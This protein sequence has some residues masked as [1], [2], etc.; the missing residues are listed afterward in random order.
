[1]NKADKEIDSKYHEAAEILMNE[2]RKEYSDETLCQNAFARALI[3]L[4]PPF[5]SL[6][7]GRA[8]SDYST[9]VKI[10]GKEYTVVNCEFKND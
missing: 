2:M 3:G 8:N 6:S 10:G 7:K 5:L 1:M 9:T 4:S